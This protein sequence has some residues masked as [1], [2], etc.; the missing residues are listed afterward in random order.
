M[1]PNL[2]FDCDD[3]A[4]FGLLVSQRRDELRRCGLLLDFDDAEES[5]CGGLTEFICGSTGVS[6]CILFFDW[7]NGQ[8]EEAIVVRV[9]RM[10]LAFLQ[11]DVVFE[12][13]KFPIEIS[14]QSIN[15]LPSYLRQGIASDLQ[16]HLGRGLLQGSESVLRPRHSSTLHLEC[17][18]GRS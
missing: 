12:P 2:A 9:E 5:A 7:I 4:L 15:Q 14:S 11:L 3:V 17:R 16:A 18:S 1:Y 10:T 13:E 8:S 6:A